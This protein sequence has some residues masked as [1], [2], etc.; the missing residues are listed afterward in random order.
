MSED[1][2]YEA[3]PWGARYHALTQRE[4]LGGGAAGPGKSLVLL[5]D[6]FTQIAVEDQRCGDPNYIPPGCDEPHPLRW[7]DSVGWAIHLRRTMPMLQDTL[8]RAQ[9]M[10]PKLEP[11]VDYNQATHTYTFPSGFK[12]QFGH[13]KDPG[14]W[15][16]YFSNSYTWIGF[17]ELTQFLEEQYIQIGGRLRTDDL[18]LRQLIR[19]RS[20]S[21]PVMDLTGME[22]IAM[23]NPH[24][25]RDLFVK[26]D[27]L[28]S[29]E[30]VRKVKMSDGEIRDYSY[31]YLH[32]TLKDNPNAQFRK[33]YE[34]QLR[35][36]PIHI[37]R[38]L[39]DG[40]WFVTANSF[41]A[42]VWNWNIHTC[43]T[44][45][46]PED[47]RCFRSMDWGY[48][49]PGCIHWYA[50]DPE[51]TLFVFYEFTFRGKT[52]KEVSARVKDIE[53][54]FGLWKDGRSLVTGPA[55]TQLWENRGDAGL[56]KAEEF[57][58]H[59]IQWVPADKKSRARNAERMHQRLGDHSNYTTAPGIVFFRD[60]C[61]KVI[62]TLPAVQTDPKNTNEP[63]DG[64]DDHWIDSAFYGVAF[65]SRGARGIPKKKH[66]DE[67]ESETPKKRVATGRGWGYGM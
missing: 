51:G 22:G 57:A 54:D 34:F 21:N 18:V 52:P 47:W 37:Q 19:V 50:L 16:Q 13:C 31:I 53:E 42:D 9:R 15:Q 4:A 44:F 55:D 36:R 28:G 41:F 35:S 11:R 23:R 6:P 7:G 48:R 60:R 45:K 10:F 32:A 2:I 14:D 64:G 38:A 3:S 25:V 61:P 8:A 63:M 5:M 1:L 30:L 59:G 39:I 66:R 12:Y 56:S 33:D 65:A 46:I 26:P 40:D 20:M 62:E 43:K 17:D 29:R 27:P 49:A 58:K 24:W 67:L